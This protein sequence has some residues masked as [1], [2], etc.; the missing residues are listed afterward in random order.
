MPC[1]AQ[2]ALACASRDMARN[3]NAQT[4]SR[5]DHDRLC[6]RPKAPRTH[7]Y[8]QGQQ[9]GHHQR[10]AEDDDGSRN[11]H[12]QQATSKG[13][14]RRCNAHVTHAQ[15]MGIMKPQNDMMGGE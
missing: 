5:I 13:D 3:A 2:L 6:I 9:Y 10:A 7:R 14:M 4:R 1:Y 11:R 12:G 8:G 15:R